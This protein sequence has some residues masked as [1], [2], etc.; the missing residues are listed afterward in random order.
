MS[1][2]GTRGCSRTDH[3]S[4]GLSEQQCG[5]V[6]RC[7]SSQVEMESFSRTIS[8]YHTARIVPEWF[9]VHNAEFQLISWLPNLPDLNTTEHTWG[10]GERQLRGKNHHVGISR[11]SSSADFLLAKD[12]PT[13]YE[14]GGHN[15]LVLQCIYTAC[16]IDILLLKGTWYISHCKK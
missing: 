10:I 1:V 6:T 14:I 7:L 3:E 12:R 9:Q 15:A 11:I 8:A 16:C 13:R 4:C 5:P 2:Y